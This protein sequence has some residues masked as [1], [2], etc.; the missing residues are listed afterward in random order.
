MDKGWDE[1]RKRLIEFL[2]RQQPGD[3]LLIIEPPTPPKI[4]APTPRD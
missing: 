1:F 4:S 3:V 2:E